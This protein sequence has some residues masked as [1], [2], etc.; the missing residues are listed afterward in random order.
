MR[1]A[2][3][4]IDGEF[5]MLIERVRDGR[6]YYLFPGGTV[7]PGETA[8]RAAVRET[9][10]ELGLEVE[11]IRPVAR[12][13]FGQNE[14]IYFLAR[15]TGGTFG[16]GHGDEMSGEAFPHA[17]SYRAVR[18]PVRQLSTVD[19]R[20]AELAAMVQRASAAGWPE[21]VTDLED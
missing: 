7:E 10:E 13:T 21:D 14:Q 8:E 20:P 9:V 18:W 15:A 1:A 11:I 4:V 17:G 16:M 2:A 19:V 12:A 5:V 3:V 6:R